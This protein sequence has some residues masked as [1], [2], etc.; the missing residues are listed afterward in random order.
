MTKA[1]GAET[2]ARFGDKF[3]QFIQHNRV[4]IFSLTGIV[5]LGLVVFLVWWG[6]HGQAL[7][8]ATLAAEELQ[9]KYQKWQ[10]EYD[11]EKNKQYKTEL[12]Q[13]IET[14]IRDHS[15]DIAGQRAY[16][17]RFFITRDEVMKG[18]GQGLTADQGQGAAQEDK[19]QAWLGMLRDL[20]GA[21]ACNS[22][23]YLAEMSLYDAGVVI[24][25][26]DYY[27]QKGTYLLKGVTVDAV[28]E[29]LPKAFTSGLDFP[30]ETLD[31]LALAVYTHFTDTYPDSVDYPHVLFSQARLL[32]A[33]ADREKQKGNAEPA[34]RFIQ[35]VKDI[36]FELETDYKNNDWTKIAKNRN[37][38]LKI[39]EGEGEKPAE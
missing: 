18:A 25:E 22:G 28:A 3:A 30:V 33:K 20:L 37:I 2:K 15:G 4:F 39:K 35:Q 7:K 12:L 17:T 32:D 26:A 34:A 6:V 24:E 38:M 11:T 5:I 19:S 29:L 23:S 21:A 9:E 16:I 13:Y 27:Q 10:N 36:F 31:D 1:H 8:N 14:L